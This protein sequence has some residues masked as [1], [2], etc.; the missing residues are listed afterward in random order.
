MMVNST[1]QFLAKILSIALLGAVSKVWLL[2]YVIGDISLF[3]IF[4]ILQNNIFW[5]IPIRSYIG[6]IAFGLLMRVLIKVS[7]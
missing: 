3:L 2:S 4:K 1:S 7:L 5:Y 6:S